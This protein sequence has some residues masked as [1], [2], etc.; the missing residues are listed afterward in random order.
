MLRVLKPLSDLLAEALVFRSGW[1]K[2]AA[3]ERVSGFGAEVRLAF[4][5]ESAA[6][7]G[8]NLAFIG[9]PSPARGISGRRETS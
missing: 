9:G 2:H 4:R 6:R 7:I 3:K 8:E 1:L 5:A